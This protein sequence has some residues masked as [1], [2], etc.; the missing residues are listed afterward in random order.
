MVCRKRN[1]NPPVDFL[2][3]KW[4]DWRAKAL[5][6]GGVHEANKRLYRD[7]T[8]DVLIP[9]YDRKC[10]YCERSRGYEVQIDHYRPTKTRNNKKDPHYNQP[11]YYWLAYTYSNL[12]PLCSKC[13]GV[14]SNKF[15]LLGWS[16]TNRIDH[17]I[18]TPPITDANIHDLV[19]LNKNEKPFLL[20]PEIEQ[21]LARHFKFLNDGR[22]K[23]RTDLGNE[24]IEIVQLDRPDLIIDRKKIID[25][26]V[27]KLC[28]KFI[29]YV[30]DLNEVR[31]KGGLEVIF[32]DIVNGV[33]ES[34]VFSLFYTFIYK[35][36]EYYIGS[37]LPT[38]Y[39]THK[40][41]DYW[42]EFKLEHQLA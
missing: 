38:P 25:D 31:L 23:G 9:L 5:D 17:H 12:M 6:D 8:K 36:F 7:T 21:N 13:N 10:A 19:W 33:Q 4:D 14:K 28:K 24:T 1:P 40:A 22:I 42:E 16:E 35:Y 15:P 3:A 26:I 32:D 39:I 20:H 2:D 34:H 27:N 37:Q 11:G 29:Q 41:I 18:P 30:D